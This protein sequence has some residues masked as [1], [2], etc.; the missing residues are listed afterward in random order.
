MERL[1]NLLEITGVSASVVA[2]LGY[3]SLRTYFNFLGIGGVGDVTVTQL[4]YEAY[5]VVRRHS[6][7]RWCLRAWWLSF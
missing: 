1:R 7:W 5:A 2:G 6:S 3:V 4:L